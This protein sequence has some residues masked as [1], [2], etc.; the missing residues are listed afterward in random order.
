MSKSAV[1]C[2]SWRCEE[3]ATLLGIV[4]DDGSVAFAKD[5]IVVDA[6]F[7]KQAYQAESPEKRFRFSSPCRQGGCYQWKN[8]RCGIADRIVDG[9]AAEQQ[10][11][12]PPCLIRAECRWYL[13]R[14][15][16]A[17]AACPEVVT[18]MQPAA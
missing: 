16:A 8:D 18:D 5:R 15:A 10:I 12:L 4:L 17:C 2:P 13:Q 11:E 1:L 3:G 14:G 7:V 6:A 9:S